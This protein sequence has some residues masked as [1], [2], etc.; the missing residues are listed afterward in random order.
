MNPIKT[1]YRA[2]RIIRVI[3]SYDL[4]CMKC[5]HISKIT[6]N[7]GMK[8]TNFLDVTLHLKSGDFELFRKDDQVPRYINKLPNHPPAIRNNLPKMIQKCWGCAAGRKYLKG[9]R[10]S[11]KL[12]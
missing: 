5:D 4:M 1:L 11:T 3:L 7:T 8:S 10:A 9:T 2:S 12:P 6:I